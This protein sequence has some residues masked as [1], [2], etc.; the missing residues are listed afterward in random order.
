MSFGSPIWL[1]GLLLLPILAFLF[2]RAE[3]RGTGK[4]QQFVAARLLPQLAGTVNRTRRIFRFLLLLLV[5]AFVL[6][7]LARPRWGY[8]YDEVKRKGLDLL[9]AVDVSRSMLS[10]DVQPDRLERVKLATQDLINELQGDRVGLIAFAGRAFLQAPLTIDYDA[11]ID[12]IN[13]LDTRIIPEGGT[14]ISDAIGLATRTFGKSATGNRA[15]IIFTDGEELKGDA[16]GAAKAAAEAGV[17]IFTVGVGTPGGSLI[18]IEGQNGGT[19]F[20]KDEKGEVVKSKLDETRLREIAQAADGFYLH[21]ENGPRTMK[22]LF[23]DGLAKMQVADINA[24]LSRRPIERYEWPLAAAIFLFAIALLIN[25]RKRS[26]AAPTRAGGTGA[27]PSIDQKHGRH[28]GRPSIVAAAIFL[29]LVRHVSAASAGLELYEQQKFPEAYEHFQKTLQ[30]N[31]RARQ[32]DRIQFDA[33]AAAYKMKDYNKALQAFSQAL[34]SKNPH[35]QSESH[36]NLGNT[37]YERGAAEKSDAKKLTNWEGALKHYGET[38]KAE[39]QNKN[40]K[41]NYEYVKKKIEELKKKQEQKPSPTPSPS[42]SPQK[43]QKDKNQKDQKNDQQQK[44]QQQQ[45]QSEGGQGS[46]KG[47][48][49]QNNQQSPTPTPSP[50]PSPSPNPGETATPSPTPGENGAGKSPTPSPT[51]SPSEGEQQGASPTPADE[52]APSPT[53]GEGDQNGQQ[54]SPTPAGTPEKPP[55]GEV[56]GAG[57]QKPQ[58]SPSPAEAEEQPEKEGEMSPQQAARLLEAM[59]DEEQKVQLDE[60]KVVRPVYKDW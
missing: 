10:N 9:L 32:T 36:Y 5:L 25:E 41:D 28:S 8:A 1:W 23:H 58:E 34:L 21:L 31:P 27:V 55:T 44:D 52:G 54:P 24:R 45:Q 40:A 22:Q 46:G 42:P 50:S 3:Q 37:L 26:R 35:L 15:L 53:P 47:E 43:D 59:K 12:S 56:K 16:V 60:H 20:V 18:P 49:S 17:K 29:L 38:L 2:A 57:E 6:V 14:N 7:S 33:G 19:A 13:E 48:K 51:P 4:L 39:P 11:A 30:E